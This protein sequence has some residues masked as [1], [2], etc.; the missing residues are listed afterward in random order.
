MRLG[1]LFA[2]G[3][4]YRS[5]S[6]LSPFEDRDGLVGQHFFEE[7]AAEKGGHL[8]RA[9]S[10][11]GIVESLDELA[12]E[13][14]D[15]K[16]VHP[17]VR[18]VY[19]HTMATEFEAGEPDWTPLGFVWHFLYNRFV[20]RGM[21]QL[22]APVDD[23]SLPGRIKSFISL[24]D[25]D[26]DGR[27]DYRIW[28]R[29][30][31]AAKR[32]FYVGAT[33]TYRRTGPRGSQSYLV[34]VLPLWNASFTV[35]FQPVNLP[36]GGLAL[37]TREVGSYE[38]G[39]YLVFPGRDR[40][41]LLPGFGIHEEIRLEPSRQNGR[42]IVRGLHLNWWLFLRSYTIPYVLWRSVPADGEATR[43]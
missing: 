4:P 3:E 9:P 26:R 5:P 7:W 30:Y 15:P 36:R 8:I 19:E 22:N 41:S 2:F 28:V 31:E 21:E 10:D 23:D 33:F 43:R 14:F 20:A 11:A 24:L 18:H 13:A 42:E 1:N 16:L 29:I 40:Y 25:V 39:I 12:S 27:F 35:V 38:A 32:I 34:V 37:R 17:L 6:F